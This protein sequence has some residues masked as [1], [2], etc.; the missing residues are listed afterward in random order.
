MIKAGGWA[1]PHTGATPT[2][3]FRPILMGSAI[4]AFKPH[5]Q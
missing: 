5:L 3:D 4:A 2:G 1:S